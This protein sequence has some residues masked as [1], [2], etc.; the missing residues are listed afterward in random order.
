MKDHNI[1][2]SNVRSMKSELNTIKWPPINLK[3]FLISFLILFFCT[4]NFSS[5][6]SITV[7]LTAKEK[8]WIKNHP[9]VFVGG[10]PDWAPFNFVNKN[11]EY[12]GI[13]SDYLNLVAKKTGLT[14]SVSID[15][16]SNNL[17]KIKTNQ[18]D[19]LGAVYHTQEREQYLS[20]SDPYFE[21]LDYFF[22]RN[23]LKVSTFDD[24]N[25]KRVAI[26][27]QYAHEEL[28]TKH[29][30]KIKIVTVNT[31]GDAID[32]V[33][34]NRADMLYD[35]YGSLIYTLEKEGINTIIPFRSTRNLGKNFIHI[36]S[37]KN[38]PELASIINKGLQ[39]IT[40]QEER[41]IYNKWLGDSSSKNEQKI[42]FTKEE[43]NWINSH[44]IIQYG[45][46]KGWAPYDFVNER[47]EHDGVARDY[48]NEISQRTGLK[49]EPVIDDWNKLLKKIRTDEI[50]LLIAI[51]FSKERDE[52]LSF[53]S[54]YQTMIGYFFIRDDL[55]VKNLSD[56][57]GKILAIPKDYRYVK[58]ISEKFPKIKIVET[59]NMH[60]A[61]QLVV[62]K[63]AD[64]L[65][66]S[67]SVI[68]H[69]LK[70]QAI[71][72][73]FPFKAL[74]SSEASGI[75]MAAAKNNK[76]L[77]Q[78]LD[79]TIT[80]IPARVKHDIYEKWLGNQPQKQSITTDLNSE[81]KIWLANHPA[82]RIGVETTWAPYEF[83]DQSG[84]LQGF[85][86][87]LI[88][89]I[90]KQLGIEFE[91]VSKF[92]WADTLEMAKNR[93]ID[94]ISGI[95]NTP[96][97]S[98]YLLFTNPYFSPPR[99]IFARKDSPLI[100][101]ISDLNQKTIS[102]ENQFSLHELLANE[103]PHINLYPVE[104]T[105][106]ALKSLSYGVVDAYIGD[107]GAA[108]WI[109]EQNVLAN[110]KEIGN[111]A[112]LGQAE[113]SIGVRNDWKILKTILNKALA[114]LPEEEVLSLRRKWLGI[115]NKTK[116]L[117]L[118]ND[119][120]LW[121]DKHKV[122][123]F[124][125]D[126]NWLPYEAFDKQ[127]NYIGIVAD[128][129][130]LI[131]SRLGIEIS[132]VNSETWAEATEKIKS[133]EVDIISE[134]VDSELNSQLIF[135]QS[136][137][138]S[139]IVII[140]QNEADYVENI[141]QIKHNN[142]AVIKEYGYT[143]KILER[144]PEI[145]FHEVN[146]IQE[147][148]S[149]VSTGKVDA[150]LAT[151]AQ[152][153]YHISELGMNN[154]RI[155]GKTEFNTQLAFGM[156][157]EFAPLVP[158][159]NRTLNDISI[160]EKQTILT[161]WGKHKFAEKTD[162]L[163]LIQIA[164]ILMSI[165]IAVVYWNRRLANEVAQR[166]ALEAQTQ[167]LIDN[168]PL[169][170]IVTTSDGDILTANPQTLSDYNIE[171]KNINQF[172]IAN[173]YNDIED[174]LLIKQEVLE[175][176]RVS[177]KIVPFKRV[178]GEVR[179]M[180][181]SVMPITY[182]NQLALLT[183]AVDM[184]E[185]IEIEEELNR[186]KEFAES[187][188]RAKSEFLSN[189]SH[190]I[191]TPMNAIIGFTELLQEQIKQ[192]KLK[193]FVNTI[194][195]ASNNLLTLINDILDLSKIETGKFKI[196]KTACNPHDLFT[197]LGNIFMMKMRE[198]NIDFF[199]EIDPKIPE[200]LQLD[201]TRLRQVLFNLIGNAVKFTEKGHIRV[202]AYS[203]N[204]NNI[205]SQLDLVIQIED[206]GIGI[207]EDQQEL[208]FK[209]FE[210]SAGQNTEKYGGTGLGLSITKKLVTMMGGKI[211]LQSKRGEGSI[212]IVKLS[213]VDVSSIVLENKN[214]SSNSSLSTE[215]FPAKV[216]IVDDVKDNRDL[217]LASFSNSK[218]DI[219]EAENGQQAVDLAKQ[220]FDLIL[221]DIRMPIK[222]G[223]QAAKEIKEF[224]DTPI[225]A[226]TASVMT[227]EFDRLKSDNF[228]GY[229]RK[230]VLKADLINELK[231]HLAFSEK[232]IRQESQEIILV[233]DNE[234]EY[235]PYALENLEKLTKQYKMCSKNNNISEIKI[236]SD[237][238]SA[239]GLEFPINGINNF[240][241]QLKIHIDSFDIA[242]IKIS[243]KEYPV[244]IEQLK[245][246]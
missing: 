113:I 17:N 114:S 147:G 44:P 85:S 112:E 209:D 246:L 117:E 205:R 91:I 201:A 213:K 92:N 211:E 122:I 77:A 166:M 21:V 52:Y 51:Y 43:Q 142:I 126:P 191:R 87:E 121:L 33:L 78:I 12:S 23:D 36:A 151:L 225:I 158:L 243:L 186:A 168:I 229:L 234:Y 170:I 109:A 66:D 54:P 88:K 95:V 199:L 45:A 28:L 35:T 58:T 104:T 212:F 129:L 76:M 8:A 63:K 187:A 230:P 159:F 239:I 42:N 204:T 223:Y 215:F 124:T 192:P 236:F 37:R 120:K 50:D 93:E 16:W 208:I 99:A 130:K 73:I 240:A 237:S 133:G 98:K 97:R 160:T 193:S 172:N 100:S 38:A 2:F 111:A 108:N 4:I 214:E 245:K 242:A 3:L 216:L 69:L 1:N 207:S 179:S 59:D 125:G 41:Y 244:L 154:I 219:F 197:E 184:T 65:V 131:G 5:A 135:S 128:Y 86:V 149:S 132:I 31:F 10:S 138:S 176:G 9:E 22:V 231:K 173:F 206:T 71:T 48:L 55:Q 47:G 180:M 103:Y 181:I 143:P 106:D 232:S 105:A 24:L 164:A 62:E 224:S 83:I 30:P 163:L 82:I 169:Q 56:L 171:K 226:L 183:I 140:M 137:L 67:Y 165:I 39:S 189:M 161:A 227:D 53:T 188:S 175:K 203:D 32:A 96:E 174:R 196:E 7:T 220:Q 84:R 64:I 195:T 150:L 81:E 40:L 152:A 185:H 200:N 198:Q 162:Y 210:Q 60:S 155:V 134:T 233:N 80:A 146:T 144:Y 157:K 13:A 148:L 178:D 123:R 118:S 102:I 61:I 145:N 241:K 107:Q 25:N 89:L 79:K 70:K 68:S 72:N 20:F 218:I 238:I 141:E 235:L 75:H 202:K 190:E 167:A 228:S 29:F 194:Y 27:E 139:P 119:E 18:I 221:M 222:D 94:L 15:E 14:F 177:E 11:G 127:G 116:R 153:S 90:E 46:E 74:P 156:R 49:F 115:S 136:Y 217:L 34:E 19:V 110:L 6:D 26:P 182:S 57:D 101:K